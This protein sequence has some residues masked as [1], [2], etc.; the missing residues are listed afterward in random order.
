MSLGDF[1]IEPSCPACGFLLW[2]RRF[3]VVVQASVL[4][5]CCRTTIGLVDGAGSVQN[6]DDEVERQLERMLDDA[7]KG[8]G[9]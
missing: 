3:E 4:C 5:P 2:V 8:W 7:F 1:D 6:F 9:R